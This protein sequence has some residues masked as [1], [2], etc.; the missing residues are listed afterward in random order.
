MFDVGALR[1]DEE[2]QQKLLQDL[3]AH[4]GR[5]LAAQDTLLEDLPFNVRC[6]NCLLRSGLKSLD[7]LNRTSTVE[8]M[9][10]PGFGWG[11]LEQLLKTYTLTFSQASFNFPDDR[12][13][14]INSSFGRS[15]GVELGSAYNQYPLA[16]LS[17]SVRA[18]NILHALDVHTIGQLLAL[19]PDAVRRFP[20]AGSKTLDN[21]EQAIQEFVAL[22]QEQEVEGNPPISSSLTVDDVVR[23]ID[24]LQNAGASNDQRLELLGTYSPHPS[25]ESYHKLFL[26]V[27]TQCIR[28]QRRL[29]VFIEYF[30]LFSAPLPRLELA[31]RYEVTPARIYQMLI[32]SSRTEKQLQVLLPAVCSPILRFLELHHG[33]LSA[34]RLEQDL[35]DQLGDALGTLRGAGIMEMLSEYPGILP[36]V[37]ILGQQEEALALTLPVTAPLLEAVVGKLYEQLAVSQSEMSEEEVQKAIQYHWAQVA[38]DCA[39]LDVAAADLAWL[40]PKIIITDGVWRARQRRP[41]P[42]VMDRTTQ[43]GVL[44]AI[45][46][47]NGQPMLV[48]DLFANFK[49]RFGTINIPTCRTALQKNNDIFRSYGRGVYGLKCWGEFAEAEVEAIRV[50]SRRSTPRTVLDK[51][52]V[53]LEESGIPMSFQNLF[54]ALQDRFEEQDE[55]CVRSGLLLAPERFRGHGNGI[56]GLTEWGEDSEI[57]LE[58]AALEFLEQRGYPASETEICDGLRDQFSITVPVCRW[59]LRRAWERSGSI[60]PLEGGMWD[61]ADMETTASS[62]SGIS[63]DDLLLEQLLS[64]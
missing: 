17:L 5:Q 55:R 38:P 27:L 63:V 33:V 40:H 61:V 58:E 59:A 1:D 9:K 52:E 13:T 18:E 32:M 48:Q 36:G 51:V 3:F 37:T 44:E 16:R 21:I 20:S 11:T 8:L 39:P 43:V 60:V 46:A 28:S 2:A 47:E 57:V 35:A 15:I 56:Y 62:Q 4:L 34:T 31:M 6:Q 41:K 64:C 19:S 14:Q 26:A 30:G 24:Q 54:R 12:P 23:N 53:L 45:L 49:E 7:Q 10:L 25:F 29:G 50:K 22:P 42:R